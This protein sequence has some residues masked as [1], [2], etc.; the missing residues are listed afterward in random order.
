MLGVWLDMF[1]AVRRA[2]ADNTQMEHAPD[3]TRVGADLAEF[4]ECDHG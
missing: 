3:L 4:S 1:E 2:A